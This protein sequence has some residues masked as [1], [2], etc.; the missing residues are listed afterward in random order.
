MLDA[1]VDDV[2]AGNPGGHR[3]QAGLDLGH[4]ALFQCRQHRGE[5][6]DVDL[7]DQGVAVRPAGV[8]AFDIGEHQQLLGAQR[9]GQRRGCGVGVDVVDHPV[10]VRGDRRHHRNTACSNEIPHSAGVDLLDV[11]DQPDVGVDAVDA[12]AAPDRGEQV[13]VLPGDADGV[14]AVRVDEVDQFPA[15]LAEQHHA[16]HLEHLRGGDPEAA[17][18]FTGDAELLQHRADLR[19]AA[20]D[21]HGMHAAVAQE[22]HIGGES[23]FE[24]VVGHRVAAVLDHDDL[25]VERLQRG[26]G[27]GEDGRLHLRGH[28]AGGHPRV[29]R[30]R[31]E[32]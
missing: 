2:G 11:A 20:V 31:H 6:G 7:A 21:H 29:V 4:H 16:D 14:R 32:L 10:G 9:L 8:E 24:D 3:P 22:H 23:G 25:V 28:R 26:Q 1:A 5:F 13:G 17:L 12:D 18:E 27:L 30:H 19:A 15:D